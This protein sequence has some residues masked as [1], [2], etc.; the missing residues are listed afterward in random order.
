[1][2]RISPDKGPEHAIAIAKRA[3][4]PLKIAAKIDPKDRAYFKQVV[5]PLLRDPLVDFVGPLNERHKRHL[6]RG[7]C[8]LLL[9]INWPEPFGMVFIEALACGTPVLTRPLGAAPEVIEDGVTGYLRVAD[10]DLADAV[11]KLT[12]LDRTTCRQHAEERFDTSRMTDE[13]VRVYE[14]LLA[15]QRQSD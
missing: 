14:R 1:V 8:A 15:S 7:A 6:L 4:V 9:P 13:Y 11:R 5:Q 12:A 3:G 2:G 10:E